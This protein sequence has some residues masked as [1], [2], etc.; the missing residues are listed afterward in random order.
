MV[1]L[2][3]QI[4]QQT[5][6]KTHTSNYSR[7]PL[8]NAKNSKQ[9]LEKA[10]KSSAQFIFDLLD[11][12]KQNYVFVVCEQRCEREGTR[13]FEPNKDKTWGSFLWSK[14]VF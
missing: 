5:K 11:C 14:E 4:S 13:I 8:K 9:N 7:T 2:K 6:H 3:K 12:R 10:N 1:V